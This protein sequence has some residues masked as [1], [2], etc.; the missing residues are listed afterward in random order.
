M[1]LQASGDIVKE[2]EAV[3]NPFDLRR[4]F[5]ILSSFAPDDGNEGDE[6]NDDGDEEGSDEGS[7]E[8]SEGGD[9]NADIKDP[10]KKR[11]SDE[12]ASWRKKFRDTEAKLSELAAWKKEQEDKGKDEVT[13]TS[14]ALAEVTQERDTFRGAYEEAATQ[15]L[16]FKAANDAGVTDVKYLTFLLTEDGALELNDEGNIDGLTDNIAKL[17]KANP[18]LAASGSD[19]DENDEGSDKTSGRAMNGK[20]PKKDEATLAKLADKFPALRR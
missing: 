16:V 4:S 6:G 1:S 17:I 10:E 13:K 5:T 15:L 12:A 7:D 19:D 3:F 11:L 14:E 2:I 18:K 9:D 8:G 20:K